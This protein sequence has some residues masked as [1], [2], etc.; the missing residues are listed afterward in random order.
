MV[1]LLSTQRLTLRKLTTDD[2]PFILGLL[3]TPGFLRFIGDRKV[4][5]VKDA[6]TYLINGPLRSYHENDFGLWLFLLK[7]GEPVGMCGLI[8][9]EGLADV[10]IGFAMMPA[11]E[12]KGYAFEIASAVMEYGRKKFALKRIVAITTE[13]NEQSIRLLKKLG[14]IFEEFIYLPNDEEKL[15]LFGNRKIMDN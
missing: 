3:N 12:G 1:N 8:R 10:D 11:F 2:A 15:M 4:R 6:E 14:L 7:S 5:S 13:D 9:R